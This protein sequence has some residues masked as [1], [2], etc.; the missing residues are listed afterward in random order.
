MFF[1]GRRASERGATIHPA[2]IA[3]AIDPP[4]GADLDLTDF[5]LPGRHNRENAA[6]AC[7]GALA[8][9]GTLE[10]IQTAL[11]EFKGLPHRL[12]PVATI[13][14]VSYV[15]DSKSTTVDSLVRA[16]A[17][18]AS[19]V[20]LIA[21]GRDKGG[22]YRPLIEPV[23]RHVKRLIVLGEAANAIRQTL[24]AEVAVQEAASLQDAVRA[25]HRSAVP[26]DVVL[27]SPACASFDMFENYRQRGETFRRAWVNSNDGGALPP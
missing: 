1:T 12:E 22:G 15:N 25:A 17:C 16:L 10:G 7:L 11:R 26:G 3:L 24:A 18:Y 4:G 20:I 27:L 9:G 14:G 19:P 6:A 21:G 5:Q 13:G 23:R 2:R 8:L